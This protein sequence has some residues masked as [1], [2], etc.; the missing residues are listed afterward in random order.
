V[1]RCGV[2]DAGA[3]L[4]RKQFFFEKKNQKTFAPLREIVARPLAKN[5]QSFFA[6]F[7]SQKE[8]LSSLLLF[9]IIFSLCAAWK[10]HHP[11]INRLGGLG[12]TKKN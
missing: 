12:V 3:N 7:C 11:G 4:V 5:D 9:K 8:V 1:D 10:L 6:S 2:W